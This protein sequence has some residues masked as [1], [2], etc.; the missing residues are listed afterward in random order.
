MLQNVHRICPT[1]Q[2]RCPR[3]RTAGPT[4]KWYRCP[5]RSFLVQR[6]DLTWKS[7]SSKL[8][9]SFARYDTSGSLPEYARRLTGMSCPSASDRDTGSVSLPS[10]PSARMPHCDSTPMVPRHFPPQSR[11]LLRAA[12]V[13]ASYQSGYWSSARSGRACQASLRHNDMII[14]MSSPICLFQ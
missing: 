9:V 1:R 4:V 2:L 10:H 6:T 8:K 13:I 5:R 12:A 11:L 14:S 3:I 7:G